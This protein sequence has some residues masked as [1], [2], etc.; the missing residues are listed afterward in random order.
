MRRQGSGLPMARSASGSGHELL[1]LILGVK[2]TMESKSSEPVTPD[3][4]VT[5]IRQ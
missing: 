5:K 3:P 4:L 1:K 2:F